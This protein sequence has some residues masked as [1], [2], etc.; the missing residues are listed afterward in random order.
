MFQEFVPLDTKHTNIVKWMVRCGN[1]IKNYEEANEKGGNA[2]SQ[3]I[4]KELKEA[5]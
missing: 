4:R 2:L 1:N 5:A 3:M